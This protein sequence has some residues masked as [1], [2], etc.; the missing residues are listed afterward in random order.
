MVCPAS[1][2]YYLSEIVEEHT[3]L[4]KKVL[5]RI[6]YFVMAVQFLGWAV[7]GLP[8]TLSVLSIASHGVYLGNMRR[9]P[10]VQLSDPLFIASCCTFPPIQARLLSKD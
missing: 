6:I 5:L 9:F 4:A 8:L 3:V 2:L 10:F 1:G 7:D